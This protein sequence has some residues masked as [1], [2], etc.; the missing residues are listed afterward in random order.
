[1]KLDNTRN[2]QPH[3]GLIDADV[4]YVE[5]VEYGITRLAAVFSSQIPKRIGPVRSAR[6]TDIDLF[7]QYGKPAFGYSGAQR[8]MW[9]YLKAASI[10]DVSPYTS[11]S[12]YSRDNRRRAPYNLY[13]DGRS[14]VSR[15]PK[16]TKA[17][18]MGF[19]FDETAPTGG[20]NATTA[21]MAWGYASAGFDYDKKDNEY[22]IS[23]NGQPARAEEWSGGQRAATVVIQY[24]KQEKSQFWDKGGGNTPHAETIGTGTAM[25]MRDGRVWT[26]TWNRPN[27]KSGTTFTLRDGSLMTFKPGQL[28]I[29][30]LDKKRKAS[31]KPLTKPK[32]TPRPSPRPTA[33]PTPSPTPEPVQ[34]IV[35]ASPPAAS[36]ASSAVQSASP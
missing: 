14:G 34:P 20:L 26:T 33:A 7:A 31:I 5:E 11:Y 2:A 9:P 4:V 8:R 21:S 30:L 6:I 23:L 10:Y 28:W 22:R 36:A 25:V 27:A 29:V 13:F 17:H 32:V 18:D 16:A 12:G 1:M 15:A 3:A 19:V 24:V 35:P